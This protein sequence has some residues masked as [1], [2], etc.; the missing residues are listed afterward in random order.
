[1][2][3]KISGK[4]ARCLTGLLLTV[5]MVLVAVRLFQKTTPWDSVRPARR[6]EKILN[7]R[8]SVLDSYTSAVMKRSGE[9]G[10]DIRTLPEDMII[11]CFEND[12]L[13]AWRHQ[14]PVKNDFLGR[15][16]FRQSIGRRG[17]ELSSPLATVGTEYSFI[18]MGPGWYLVRKSE[19]GS[20]V[21][22]SG[23]E[24]SNIFTRSSLNSVNPNLKLD[25]RFSVKPLSHSE[26]TAV[27]LDGKPLF[28]V[29]YESMPETISGNSALLW[30]AYAL[31]LCA[32]LI[33]MHTGKG[34]RRYVM[35]LLSIIASGAVMIL[36]G[37]SLREET[38]LFSPVLY[39]DGWLFSSFGAVLL[40]NLSVVLAI[41]CLYGASG[42]FGEIVARKGK[43]AAT[44]VRCLP[45]V[46][47]AC[48]P[49]LIF[50]E[51]RSIALNSSIPLDLFGLTTPN[52]Y[53]V[54]F[55]LS[56][57]SV[58][59]M[60]ALLLKMAGLKLT[61]GSTKVAISVALAVF[62]VSMSSAFGLRR[63][64]ARVSILAN[65]LS[66]D[67]DIALEMRLRMIEHAIAGDNWIATLSRV[68]GSGDVILNRIMESYLVRASQDY[69]ISVFVYGSANESDEAAAAIRH[70]VEDGIPISEGS[71]FVFC[72]ANG[73]MSTY[74]ALF[75]YYGEQD[76][77]SHVLLR[78]E[79]KSNGNYVG[80]RALIE[81]SVPGKVT[82][83]SRYSYA[84]YAGK[85][86]VSVSGNYTYPMVIKDMLEYHIF[87]TSDSHVIYD[88]YY[89]HINRI[90]E[91]EVILISRPRNGALKYCF[92]VAFISLLVYLALLLVCIRDGKSGTLTTGRN[93]Y[94]SRVKSILIISLVVTLVTMAGVSVAFVYKRN[95]ANRRALMIDKINAVQS[96]L[97][98]KCKDYLTPDEL[99]GEGFAAD[100][101]LVSAV[102]FT[103]I[104][105]Y[106][107]DG[108]VFASTA[109]GIYERMY[110]G[111]RIDEGALYNISK[112][113][114]RYYISD[115]HFGEKKY[116]T[117]YAPLRNGNGE[118]LAIMAVPYLNRNF[119]FEKEAVQHL[120]IVFT[121]FLI[122]LLF[123]RF[124]IL[125]V[126]DKLF[127]PLVVMGEKM[128]SA[129]IG[130][131][132]HIDYENEDE[133]T[134]LVE[135]Y[136]RMV[137]ELS[138]STRQ[139]AQAERDRAW[140]SMA[141]QVAHEIK[142]PL[143]PMKLQ[144]QRL[145]RLKQK[146]DENWQ[147]KFEEA[148][149]MLLDHIDMLSETANE[150]ST[151]AKLYSEPSTA[152]DLDLMLKEEVAMFDK[153]DGAGIVYM[154]FEKA[155]TTGPKPQLARVFINL[156]GNA[157]Q[158][159]SHNDEKKILVS[160]R[161]SVREGFYD[162]VFEDNGSGVA[163]ENLD[164][165]FTPNFTT[166]SGGTGLG[167]AISKSVLD[168]CGATISYSRSFS[169]GGACFTVTYP[170]SDE[171]KSEQDSL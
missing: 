70:C 138:E 93:F 111:S 71:H 79:P 74:S 87:S 64:Q 44:A 168:K 160:L 76:G 136:N 55:Y 23:L 122:L 152:I 69:D 45:I 50:F 113:S 48:L 39:A 127:R 167:L 84:R 115:D 4:F 108:K 62:L 96:L 155:L 28:K 35:S 72:P 14:F 19:S 128:N 129:D 16:V 98:E 171:C 120:M 140:S 59:S 170:I 57:I 137:D 107:T 67:R 43:K 22:I 38:R 73:A 29:V 18:N 30:I 164:K 151:F 145:I 40:L 106:T 142:N 165:L 26:G 149:S 77:I 86:L 125:A 56:M 37:L 112:L 166:K 11:Y 65:R 42:M 82:L 133:L 33:F 7:H 147:E 60:E 116:F 105:L 124:A 89:H 99:L 31:F 100:L 103:D 78:M 159:V 143:T 109:P 3:M 97:S 12:S 161:K 104:T 25:R 156:L 118:V 150:F 51:F 32:V 54:V 123:A 135:S 101:R 158:A 148:S 68:H 88:G 141:R 58:L 94:R 154:G 114:R 1:M 24:I 163:E 2:N 21:V 63:E 121:V 52:I 162:I 13:K 47:V 34:M 49:T 10:R 36:L 169:L 132:E 75:T 66:I 5:S 134:S 81:P 85:E 110:L 139:L 131:L 53:S 20:M 83:P 119:D 27:S 146:G 126:A 9:S 130:R 90:S 92:A 15:T 102:N 91:D 61:S 95:E 117:L 6:L 46:L 153:V 8:I 144:L 41:L 80:Y 17:D 157:I